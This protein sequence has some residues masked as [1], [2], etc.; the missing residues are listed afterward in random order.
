MQG[1]DYITNRMNNMTATT[2]VTRQVSSI[3]QIFNHV[4]IEHD[5]RTLPLQTLILLAFVTVVSTAVIYPSIF[6]S[7][8]TILE[9]KPLLIYW[10]RMKESLT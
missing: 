7:Y 8:S 3:V 10:Q 1:F 5:R 9:C 2:G 6:F 4:S